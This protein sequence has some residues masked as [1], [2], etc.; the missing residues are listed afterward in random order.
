[1]AQNMTDSKFLFAKAQIVSVD[2]YLTTKV[3]FDTQGLYVTILLTLSSSVMIYRRNR[4][5]V[6]GDLETIAKEFV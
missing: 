4:K 5:G 1:M 6:Y 2:H 3:S